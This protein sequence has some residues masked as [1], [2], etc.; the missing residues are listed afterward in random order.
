[1]P[2]PEDFLRSFPETVPE[3]PD[4][5]MQDRV[6]MDGTP[7]YFFISVAA[8]R[9]KAVVPQARFV[10]ILRVCTIQCIL[11]CAVLHWNTRTVR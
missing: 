5:I 2:S 3:Q 6:L 10:I 8:P 1:M 11:P 7:D 9:I 4:G